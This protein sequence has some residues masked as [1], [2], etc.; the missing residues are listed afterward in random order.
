MEECFVR[1]YYAVIPGEVRYDSRLSAN[2]KLLYGEITALCNEKGYCWAGNDYFAKLY[3]VSERS[4]INWINSL[5]DAGYITRQLEY[6]PNSKNIKKRIIKIVTLG[7]ILSSQISLGVEK[8]FTSTDEEIFT[9]PSEENFVEN[10]TYINNTINTTAIGPNETETNETETDEDEVICSSEHIDC[11]PSTKDV[12][13][14]IDL[15]NKLTRFGI[16]PVYRIS[17]SSTRAKMLR[18]RLRE[19]G[20]EGYEKAIDNI[21]KSQFLQGKEKDASW[22]CFDWF[23]KPNNFIKVLEGNYNNASKG[24]G[25]K[26]E[27]MIFE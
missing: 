10:N 27:G 9:Y 22:F 23:V 12:Q 8:N 16:V 24:T 14:C 1:N 2:A 6:Y 19:Y 17:G 4:I 5:V 7:D 26:Y 25:S 21:A 20:M 15:W 3:S 13:H 18:C 11:N